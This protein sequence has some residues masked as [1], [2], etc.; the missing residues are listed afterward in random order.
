[1]ALSITT[2][3]ITISEA[4]HT[5]KSNTT[6]YVECHN[7]EFRYTECRGFYRYAEWHDAECLWFHRES[8]GE[9]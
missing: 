8:L 6:S 4:R 7:A 3:N 9:I 2:L 5:A 1:M